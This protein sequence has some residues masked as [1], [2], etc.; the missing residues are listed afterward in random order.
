MFKEVKV[1]I[2]RALL[3]GYTGL[4]LSR[5]KNDMTG[6]LDIDIFMDYMPTETVLGE[7]TDGQE[8]HV[9]IGRHLSF[10]GSIDSRIDVGNS[11]SYTVSL[12]CRGKS[13]DLID[14]SQQHESGTILNTDSKSLV[15]TLVAPFNTVI[16]WDADIIDVDRFRLRDGA[17]V[18]SEIGR[19]CEQFSLFCYEL[20]D[21]TLRFVDTEGTTEG[22]A[23]ILGENILSFRTEKSAQKE[24]SEVLVKGQRVKPTEWGEAAV[25]S[26]FKRVADTSVPGFSPTTVQLYGD[27]T[28]A[29]IDRRV[30]YEVNKRSSQS[31]QISV[32]VFH[33]QQSTLEP[34]EIGDRH[35][36]EIPP[37]GVSGVF[38]ITDISYSLE[39]ESIQTSL[40]LSPAPI[41]NSVASD[42]Q[43][44][45][46]G[47]E[48]ITTST[49]GVGRVRLSAISNTWLGPVLADVETAITPVVTQFLQSLE[50]AADSVPLKLPEGFDD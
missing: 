8:I 42:S 25:I 31:K 46:A 45:L 10:T 21:G 22:E 38:E 12:T 39:V 32:D 34:W 44:I 33:L 3:R 50:D 35:Y 49:T 41:K 37:A 40:T 15:E 18:I 47:L 9:Y 1:F 6:Q 16:Q 5:S 17:K 48:E 7:V 27:A 26:T 30:Q 43:T 4:S 14:S 29:N 11:D 23:L 36:V 24:R 20:R 19:I 13:K 2:G 28:E